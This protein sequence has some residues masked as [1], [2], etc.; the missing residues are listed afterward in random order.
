[1]KLFTPMLR[2][3][4]ITQPIPFYL[5]LELSAVLLATFLPFSPVA[6]TSGAH[7]LMCVQLMRQTTV[8]IWVECSHL[9]INLILKEHDNHQSQDWHMVSW[10]DQQWDLYTCGQWIQALELQNQVTKSPFYTHQLTVYLIPGA[11]R[12]PSQPFFI[13]INLHHLSMPWLSWEPYVTSPNGPT[14]MFTLPM[15]L[16]D[17]H[18]NHL[19]YPSTCTIHLCWR[20]T[21]T[22]DLLLYPVH[23]Y[24][25]LILVHTSVTIEQ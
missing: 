8:D 11:L 16:Q 2:V 23:Y 9:F 5:T 1:M 12:L 15:E 6:G 20:F 18:Y 3:F 25:K 7:K 4:S 24:S 21:S 22:V 10:P 19:L 14:P 13:P 17:S